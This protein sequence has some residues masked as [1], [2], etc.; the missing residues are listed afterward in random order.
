MSKLL[1]LLVGILVSGGALFGIIYVIAYYGEYIS[2][3]LGT[4]FFLVLAY[5]VGGIIIEQVKRWMT[6]K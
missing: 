1:Q 3:V 5:G 2:L 4:L 6:P